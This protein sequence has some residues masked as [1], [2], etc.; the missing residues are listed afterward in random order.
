[1][2]RTVK[3]A[4]EMMNYYNPYNGNE[5][6]DEETYNDIYDAMHKLA[7]LNI[8]SNDEWR[9]IYKHDEKLSGMGVTAEAIMY[10]LMAQ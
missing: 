7:C 5:Y 6:G 1:M 2:T 9:K 3:N 4:L 10:H 8:I